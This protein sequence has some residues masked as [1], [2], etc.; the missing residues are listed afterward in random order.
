MPPATR[1]SMKCRET[2]RK[3]STSSWE[4]TPRI[5]SRFFPA[6]PLA[7]PSSWTADTASA[8]PRRSKSNHEHRSSLPEKSLRGISADG[9]SN[10]RGSLF[11]LRPSQQYLSQSRFPSHHD[12]GALRRSFNAHHAADGHATDRGIREHGAG[13]EPCSFQDNSRGGSNRNPVQSR[14]GHEV[15]AP[16]GSGARQR[17]ARRAS[18]GNSSIRGMGV[19]HR[20]PRAQPHFEWQRPG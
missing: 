12:S 10:R 13:R 16:V 6:S 19:S 17:R 2:P 15:R 4:S 20:L 18:G 3:Q 8:K 11:F 14:H 1:A 9:L 5:A 7:K